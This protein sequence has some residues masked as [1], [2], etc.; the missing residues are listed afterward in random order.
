MKATEEIENI[1]LAQQDINFGHNSL[2]ML[3]DLFVSTLTKAKTPDQ[4][5]LMYAVLQ[6]LNS[7]L[8][9]GEQQ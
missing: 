4:K 7:T 1:L 6:K 2:R 8:E 5:N 9:S 3:T